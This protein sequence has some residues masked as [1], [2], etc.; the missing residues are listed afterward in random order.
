MSNP[1][2]SSAAALTKQFQGEAASAAAAESLRAALHAG[3]R[4]GGESAQERAARIAAQNAQSARDAALAANFGRLSTSFDESQ[5]GESK[6]DMDDE[7]FA[8]DLQKQ[9]D[10]QAE[11]EAADEKLA[12]QFEKAKKEGTTGDLVA[13]RVKKL[14]PSKSQG[15][16][17]RGG[18]ESGR[19][20]PNSEEDC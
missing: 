20:T 10:A 16:G 4:D 6:T 19:N 2:S 15:M 11:Q 14:S 13:A 17:G 9:L 12:R 5:Q 8:R 7:E 1:G 18:S 3:A